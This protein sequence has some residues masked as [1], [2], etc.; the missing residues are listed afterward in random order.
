[1]RIDYSKLNLGER[2]V[3]NM[4]KVEK[5]LKFEFGGKNNENDKKSNCV[6]IR[7]VYIGSGG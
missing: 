7:V 1:M 3:I 5:L 4:S 2:N 6:F